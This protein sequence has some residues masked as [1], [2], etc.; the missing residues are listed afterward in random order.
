ML[1][2]FVFKLAFACIIFSSCNLY[3]QKWMQKIN[4][5]ENGQ[6]GF[7]EIQKTFYEYAKGKPILSIVKEYKKFK[8]WEYFLESRV[9]AQGFF[10]SAILRTE[11][12][13]LNFARKQEK[14]H[15]GNWTELGPMQTP[16]WFTPNFILNGMRSG[17]GRID[18]IEFH[19]SDSNIMWAGAP[20]GGMWK[21]TNGGQ[22]W[23]TTT[24]ELPSIGISDI[25]VH[26]TNPDILYIGTGD[27]DV[28]WAFSIGVLKSTDGGLTFQ[29]TGL[30]HQI[31]ENAVITKI[32]INPDTPDIVL[33]ATSN[34]IF[35][36]TDAGDN[37]TLIFNDN[38][39]NMVYKPGNPQIVYA[40]TFRRTGGAKVYKS[41]DGGLSFTQLT[42]TG[43]TSSGVGRITFAV[44]PANPEV[45]Y[46]VACKSNSP[47][48]LYGVYKSENS[49]DTW[50]R[51]IAGS[52]KNLLGRAL[53]GNDTEGYGWYTL[54]IEA[55]PTDA[56]EVYVGGINIWKSTDG[57]YT[58]S[59][60]TSENPYAV[61]VTHMWVDHHEIRINP[62]NGA[63][64]TCNDGGIYKSNDNA[65]N[66][67]DITDGLCINQ[68]YRIG[69]AASNNNMVI[70]GC[71]D[72]FG[73]L[74]EDGD[75]K[76]V[77]TGE[78]S[79]HFIDYTNPNILYAYGFMFGM[80]R[81]GNRGGNYVN[82]NPP[83]VDNMH[84]LAP[85]IIHPTDPNTIY[86]GINGIYKSTNR[87]DD[88]QVLVENLSAQELESIV[89]AS[90]DNNYMYAASNTQI[91]KSTDGGY[92][93]E[94]IKAGLPSNIFIT[95]IA[96]S[97]TNPNQLW[98]SSAR[99]INNMKVYTSE[100]GGQSWQNI[101]RN[102][103]NI[104]VN[105]IVYEKG[106]CNGIYV[107]TDIGVFYKNNFLENWIDFSDGLPNVI[108]N[109]IE[110][111]YGAQK[112]RS[113]TYG[114]GLWESP[115]YFSNDSLVP[116]FMAESVSGCFGKIKLHNTTYGSFDSLRWN[117]GDGNFSND[118][119]PIHIYEN[120]GEYVVELFTY[121]DDSVFSISDTINAVVVNKPECENQE[122]CGPGTVTF[123]AS[124][125]GTINWYSDAALNNLIFT[126]N[127]FTTSAITT[128]TTYY[129]T[130]T[131]SGSCVSEVKTVTAYIRIQPIAD[132]TS[133]IPEINTVN[134]Q[135]L[136]SDANQY[137]WEFGDGDTSVLVNPSH[138]YTTFG[139]M[140]VILIA[141]N[142]NCS[143]TAIETIEIANEITE[144]SND[145]V[146][147]EIVPNPNS[148][149]FYVYMPI[150]NLKDVKIDLIAV[151]GKIKMENID[152]KIAP[153]KLFINI[154]SLEAG[155]YFVKVKCD[156]KT[157]YKKLIIKNN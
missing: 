110:I 89:I 109:E 140:E 145:A 95:D 84:W 142:G 17:T 64:F 71:Q 75:W 74:Y 153:N 141:M 65:A 152:F 119:D 149:A 60:K 156:K 13:K 144:Y 11:N 41:V 78:G 73:M 116:H 26:P 98:V 53:N 35:R 1:K 3:S 107:G 21:T 120:S 123:L 28:Y 43:I 85:T 99:F 103:P 16:L 147:V 37:W 76:A 50:T 29:N 154:P 47:A 126:G 97:Y 118:I 83:G 93:W 111:Q 77:Y 134:F 101:S 124:A 67:S 7:Y 96:V 51:T 72:Q 32:L 18:C 88:W 31:S 105:T 4:Y 82:I 150:E 58:W 125:N 114:R 139:N 62:H 52:S 5:P 55:S 137:L 155:T 100:N 66:F 39:K 38:F 34:G 48:G 46:F 70:A 106:T 49:G 151:D 42:N 92:N 61:G 57:G 23:F 157:M 36:S 91:W 127:N 20:T 59:I 148:G 6:V 135:N 121:R 81:S 94:S 90:S 33:A 108:N 102:L 130:N 146:N 115:L 44:T 136:S 9:D 24:N 19:P 122:N 113:G 12:E 68:I 128:N 63:L 40:S 25:V 10:P 86:L 112:I 8:R 27:R 138:V 143:D 79:E 15:N 54:S 14:T 2:V 56:N 69:C 131:V 87:G 22:T 104:P 117:F 129:L 132:F 133:A 45:V 80:I 30:V